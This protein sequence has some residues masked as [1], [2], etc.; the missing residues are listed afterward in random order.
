M[1]TIKKILCA[2]DLTPASRTAFERALSI[3]RVSGARLYILHAV[4]KQQPFSWHATER[5]DLFAS[6]RRRAER[7]EIP[8]PVVELDSKQ[9]CRTN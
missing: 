1:T 2:V 3:A 8:V 4:P 9:P 7:E 5:L 6:L